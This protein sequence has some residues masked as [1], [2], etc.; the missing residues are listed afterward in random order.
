MCADRFSCTN[1]KNTNSPNCACNTVKHREGDTNGRMI[2]EI[3]LFTS[4]RKSIVYNS[5]VWQIH[6][7]STGILKINVADVGSQPLRQSILSCLKYYVLKKP[8]YLFDVSIAI[9]FM[10]KFF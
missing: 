2:D 7:Y 3:S 6:S 10:N 9:N 4:D 5:K 8:L 1:H